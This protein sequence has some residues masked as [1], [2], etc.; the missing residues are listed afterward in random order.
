[1]PHHAISLA[2]AVMFTLFS[3]PWH[4]AAE[5]PVI[6]EVA[7]RGPAGPADEYIEL[8]NTG[9]TTVNIGGWQ[10]YSCDSGGQPVLILIFPA[11]TAMSPNDRPGQYLL[12]AGTG[13]QGRPAYPGPQTPDI[14]SKLDMA[15][16]AG[17]MLVDRY[18]RPVD[19]IG[20]GGCDGYPQVPQCEWADDEAATRR[21]PVKPLTGTGY[22]CLPATPTNSTG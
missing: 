5:T 22:S 20:T 1:M 18:R 15:P 2:T 9:D 10:L 8:H 3:P 7:P 17:W 21:A 12:L 6:S 14:W 4:S 11:G 19:G 16:S 13:Y